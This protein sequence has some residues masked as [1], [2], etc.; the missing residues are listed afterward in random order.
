MIRIWNAETEGVISVL[1][2]HIGCIRAVADDPVIQIW[3][4]EKLFSG[5]SQGPACSFNSTIR[6]AEGKNAVPDRTKDARTC[7]STLGPADSSDHYA[8]DTHDTAEDPL[9]ASGFTDDSTWDDGWVALR[10]TLL[11]TTPKSSRFVVG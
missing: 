9:S 4:G 11:G 8:S 10:I 6:S 3:D 5:Q 7:D 1:G 2:G